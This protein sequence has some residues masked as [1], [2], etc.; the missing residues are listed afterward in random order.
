MVLCRFFSRTVGSCEAT[1]ATEGLDRR[2]REPEE[3]LLSFVEVLADEECLLSVAE[4]GA[5]L[6]VAFPAD[7][8]QAGPSLKGW[9]ILVYICVC[10]NA[11]CT[12][13]ILLIQK[14]AKMH[15]QTQEDE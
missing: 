9:S 10:F 6:L 5:R 8:S 12:Y 13:F 11:V 3:S 1:E 4:V 7:G 2:P 15:F 14:C